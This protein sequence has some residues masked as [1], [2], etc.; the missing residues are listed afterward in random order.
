MIQ[1]GLRMNYQQEIEQQTFRRALR[2]AKNEGDEESQA[3]QYQ[4]FRDRQV[5][6][7]SQGF[8]IMPRTTSQASAS[9]TWGEWLTYLSDD[10]DSQPRI[11]VHLNDT[12]REFRSEDLKKD[13]PL[14]HRIDKT[15]ASTGQIQQSNSAS[16]LNTQ[17][18][19][20]TTMTLNTNNNDQVSSTLT[21]KVDFNW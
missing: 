8:A 4:H 5:P 7:P 21:S 14:V 9:V 10:R 16:K 13:E 1:I 11:I 15:I 6:N 18:T 19:E 20:Q 3:I 2:V 17:T 12:Q